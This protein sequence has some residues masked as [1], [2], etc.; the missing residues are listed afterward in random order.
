MHSKKLLSIGLLSLMALVLAACAG[1]AGDPGPAGPAGPA[2][3]QG[4]AG[5]ALTTADL[6]CTECHND[7]TL[8]VGKEAAWE[9]SVHGTGEAYVRGTSAGCAGCHSGGA[10]SAMVAAGQNPSEVEAGDPNPTRQDCRTCHAI[11][12]SYTGADW[13]LETTT[14]VTLYAFEGVTFDGGE[15]NLCAT[16]HQARR[17][18][19]VTDGI[20]NWDSSHYGPHHGPQSSMLLGNGGAGVEG[21]PAA[22][23]AMVE[24]TC[25]SCH[26]GEGASHSFEP[27]VAACTGCH[28]DAEDFDINGT[29]TEVEAMLGELK[30]ALIAKG[31]LTEEDAS[32]VGE[33]PEALGA[34][35]WNYIYIAQEDKSMGVHNPSYTKAL[36]EASI[37]AL[38]E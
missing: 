24:N 27:A 1:A 38:A 4:P 10:F 18:F 20:V 19:E 35:L 3:L 17:A 28:A 31:M 9:E 21:K 32:V 8:I 16:C 34:A 11:H 30:E 6:A 15:G 23:Y 5:P 13:A 25:V 22:H 37:A 12:T 14:P 33:Y 29:Q 2:G 26:V 7:T 36:L